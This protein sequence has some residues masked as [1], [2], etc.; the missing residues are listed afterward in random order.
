MKKSFL[1]MILIL[2]LP[3]CSIPITK[4]SENIRIVRVLLFYNDNVS[5]EKA[6]YMI[7]GASQDLVRETGIKL[8]VVK[9]M[10]LGEN[11]MYGNITQDCDIA[12]GQIQSL[13]WI[14]DRTGKKYDIALG[15]ANDPTLVKALGWFAFK[16]FAKV[17]DVYR[18]WIVFWD[19]NQRV[20]RHEVYHCF[21]FTVG[22]TADLMSGGLGTFMPF[23]HKLIP[24]DRE[25]ILKNKWRDFNKRPWIPEEH[26]RDIPRSMR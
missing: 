26:I 21:L 15:F 17:D 3:A 9:Y 19:P 11:S 23:S 13:A 18:R 8:V 2:L 10:I 12:I 24:E 7:E 25:E 20:V 4:E 6:L 5:L 1:I 22:H 16:P 14:V